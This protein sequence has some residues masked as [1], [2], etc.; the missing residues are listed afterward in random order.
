[1]GQAINNDSSSWDKRLNVHLLISLFLLYSNCCLLN[2]ILSL[3]KQMGI[4]SFGKFRHCEVTH[5]E[6]LNMEAMT[7]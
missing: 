3:K 5:G 6:D 2:V 4:K 1:M 7:E